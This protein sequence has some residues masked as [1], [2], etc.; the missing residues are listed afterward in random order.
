MSFQFHIIFTAQNKAPPHSR[1]LVADK[2]TLVKKAQDES[3]VSPP[4]NTFALSSMDLL[5]G[6]LLVYLETRF[7]TQ[8][9]LQLFI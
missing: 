3:S 9:G 6:C 7:S 2:L 8:T 4:G 5:I 1:L